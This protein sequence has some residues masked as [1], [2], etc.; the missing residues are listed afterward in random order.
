MRR[1]MPSAAR[2]GDLTPHPGV[3]H[4]PGVPTVLIGGLP[5]AVVGDMHAC[6]LPAARRPASAVADRAARLSRPS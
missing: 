4:R 3:D 1:A 2:V 5:A 6:S